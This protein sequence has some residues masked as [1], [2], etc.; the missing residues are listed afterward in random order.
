MAL[1][2]KIS[3]LKNSN[4]GT[5]LVS[6]ETSNGVFIDGLE[7]SETREEEIHLA[8]PFLERASRKLKEME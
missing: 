5:P 2:R 4:L 8:L 3:F 1:K 6:F 7:F